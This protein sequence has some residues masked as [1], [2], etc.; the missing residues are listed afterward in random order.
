MCDRETRYIYKSN[1]KF[2][3]DG[4][5][6][7]RTIRS[8]TGRKPPT[9]QPGTPAISRPIIPGSTLR[10]IQRSIPS[11]GLHPLQPSQRLQ[12][13]WWSIS[14]LYSGNWGWL[15]TLYFALSRFS[16]SGGFFALAIWDTWDGATWSG[17]WWYVWD[18]RAG[19]GSGWKEYGYGD[20][21]GYGYTRN[22]RYAWIRGR[23]TW[24]GQRAIGHQL[25]ISRLDW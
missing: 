10:S 5:Q 6:F 20:G 19:D 13:W 12:R 9:T 11:S 3:H 15:R 18:G 1:F 24:N 21:Y 23:Y 16:M 22:G 25:S 8:S 2:N 14:N 7:R 4:R 17:R